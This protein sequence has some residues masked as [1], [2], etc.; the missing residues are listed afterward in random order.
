MPY[1]IQLLAAAQTQLTQAM[2]QFQANNPNKEFTTGMQHMLDKQI[3]MEEM[4]SHHM[5]NNINHLPQIDVGIEIKENVMTGPRACKICGEIGHLSKECHDEWP[6]SDASY[7]DKGYTI[8]QV[9]CFLCEGTTHIPAQCQL[10]SM[11]IGRAS[12]RERV[13]QYV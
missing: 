8:T 1:A 11:E 6:H 2:K 13:C 5:T 3:Q 9:T 12:C 10:Y 4:T 7:L